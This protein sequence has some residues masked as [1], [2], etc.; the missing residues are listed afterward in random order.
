MASDK[1]EPMMTVGEIA[2]AALHMVVLPRHINFLEAIVLP[3][4]QLYLGRG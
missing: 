1:D 2:E 4:D 3:S